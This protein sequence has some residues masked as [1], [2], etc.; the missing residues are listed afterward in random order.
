M[1]VRTYRA[2]T[3]QTNGHLRGFT[4]KIGVLMVLLWHWGELMVSVGESCFCASVVSCMVT[5]EANSLL[6]V[7][8]LRLVLD[9]PAFDWFYQLTIGNWLIGRW[10][11]TLVEEASSEE[12]PVRTDRDPIPFDRFAKIWPAGD[13]SENPFADHSPSPARAN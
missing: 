13:P 12:R 9:N 8:W 11:I 3:R 2:G 1:T 7:F 10:L 5:S 4:A 6:T